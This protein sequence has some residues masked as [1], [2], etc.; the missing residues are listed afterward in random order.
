MVL[1]NARLPAIVEEFLAQVELLRKLVSKA[2]TEI[3]AEIQVMLRDQE[4]KFW[5]TLSAIALLTCFK[6]LSG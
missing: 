6:S 1:A 3:T 4:G 2:A 5:D